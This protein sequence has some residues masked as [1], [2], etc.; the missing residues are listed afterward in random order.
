MTKGRYAYLEELNLLML[1]EKKLACL[2][3]VGTVFP[4]VLDETVWMPV[5][6]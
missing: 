2:A 5:Y 4:A 1:R 3:P 6:L